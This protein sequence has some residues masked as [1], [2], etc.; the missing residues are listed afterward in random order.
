M[1]R[2]I[3]FLFWDLMA[4]VSFFSAGPIALLQQDE[5]RNILVAVGLLATGMS[6]LIGVIYKKG[7]K[8]QFIAS[9]LEELKK[10]VKKIQATCE[11]RI[12]QGKC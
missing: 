9:A 2:V 5:L 1:V 6:F 11:Q 12:A 4:G 7:K 3:P 10:D 8:D